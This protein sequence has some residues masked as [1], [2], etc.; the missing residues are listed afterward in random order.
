VLDGGIISLV[1]LNESTDGALNADMMRLMGA[2]LSECHVYGWEN[3]AD[4]TK[5]LDQGSAVF[6]ALNP[7]YAITDAMMYDALLLIA[8]CITRLNH[9][10]AVAHRGRGAAP[11][12]I[13]RPWS[14]PEKE[15]YGKDAVP[16]SDFD[17][18][19]YGG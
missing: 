15:H 17:R 11:K 14:K 18:W 1:E 9:N 10:Y 4:L 12:P 5:H 3:I 6:R 7:K 16:I 13:E 8:D 19:Y 2:P